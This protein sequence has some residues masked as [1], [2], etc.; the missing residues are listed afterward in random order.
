MASINLL[1]GFGGQYTSSVITSLTSGQ[2]GS[3]TIDCS[4]CYTLAITLGSAS[5]QGTVQLR[6]AFAFHSNGSPIW[7]NFNN[8]ITVASGGVNAIF[9]SSGGP[10]GLMSFT[11]SL[12]AGTTQVTITGFPM[13]VTL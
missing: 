11:T 7:S 13:P 10:F 9:V 2:A 8:P 12:V 6:Q 4:K 1:P 3:D 5:G